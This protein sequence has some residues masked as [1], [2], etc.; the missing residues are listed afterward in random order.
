MNRTATQLIEQRPANLT[1]LHRQ[2]QE[3]ATRH[4]PSNQPPRE[5]K[6]D[7]RDPVLVIRGK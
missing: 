5:R 1:I 3:M 4:K 2:F 7:L 6:E